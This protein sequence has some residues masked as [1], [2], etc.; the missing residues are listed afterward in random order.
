MQLRCGCSL[1][2]HHQKKVLQLTTPTS[3]LVIPGRFMSRRLPPVSKLTLSKPKYFNPPTPNN[4]LFDQVFH[5]LVQY[6]IIQ[7]TYPLP[8]PFW[9]L[10]FSPCTIC[11]YNISIWKLGFKLRASLIYSYI[12]QLQILHSLIKY[13]N[14][15]LTI[16]SY[17]SQPF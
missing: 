10:F 1:M 9:L 8:F 3:S 7:S 2:H 14:Y 17:I 16:K 6:D 13:S 12:P 11:W 5:V 4:S 15:Y